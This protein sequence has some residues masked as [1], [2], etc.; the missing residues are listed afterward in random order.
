MPSSASTRVPH[1]ARTRNMIMRNM[2][3]TLRV[4][5]ELTSYQS[6]DAMCNMQTGSGRP[7][8]SICSALGTWSRLILRTETRKCVLS[9]LHRRVHSVRI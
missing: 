2:I 9:D 8:A 3:M 6:T 5:V 7:R 4:M 1:A